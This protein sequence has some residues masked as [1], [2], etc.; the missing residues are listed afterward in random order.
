MLSLLF[1]LCADV[2]LAVT[3]ATPDR[4]GTASDADAAAAGASGAADAAAADADP[5]ADRLE[6]VT[7]TDGPGISDRDE[8]TT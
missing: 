7:R 3:A 8:P 6:D 2:Y 1:L 5:A 4:E